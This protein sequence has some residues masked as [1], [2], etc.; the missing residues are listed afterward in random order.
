MFVMNEILALGQIL[1]MGQIFAI[2]VPAFFAQV[3]LY[4]IMSVLVGV[5]ELSA[6][7]D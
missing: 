2:F 7:G 3:D 4:A 5:K 1:A 6:S